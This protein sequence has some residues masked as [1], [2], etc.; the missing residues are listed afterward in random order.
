MGEGILLTEEVVKRR[1]GV[2]PSF[3][4]LLLASGRSLG[5]LASL[6]IGTVARG[7]N[8]A[9]LTESPEGWCMGANCS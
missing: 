1:D 8:G 4:P 6:G 2:R 9:T 7:W 3:D 5:I